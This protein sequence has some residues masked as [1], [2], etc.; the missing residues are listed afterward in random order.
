MGSDQGGSE[1][2]EAVDESQEAKN[3]PVS[4]YWGI[5]PDETSLDFPCDRLDA[6]FDS[7]YFRAITIAAPPEVIF[8]WLCQMRVAPYS[9]DWLDN[10]GRQSPQK[11]IPGLDK[12][13]KGQDVMFIFE[14]EDFEPGRSV[15]IRLKRKLRFV[16]DAA[17]SYMIVPSKSGDCRLLVK[18]IVNYPRW[19]AGWLMRLFLPWGDLIMMRRQLMNF[20]N[21]A[22]RNP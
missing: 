13:D 10:F 14:I 8:R 4:V 7:A 17:I 20:K 1:G 3:W 19:I 15:T 12:L 18:L 2:G 11:I 6:S 16:A 21:L 22:E 9:Y 5:K